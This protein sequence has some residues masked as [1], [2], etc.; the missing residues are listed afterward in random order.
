[1][2]KATIK[3]SSGAVITVEGTH[4]E[5]AR[6]I[7]NYEKTS[8]VGQ[9]KEAIARTKSIRNKEKKRA[10][11]GDLLIELRESGFFDK[12][13]TLA[14]MS[15]ALEEKGFLY[16][17]TSLSGVVLGLVKHRELR[18]KKLDGRWVYGK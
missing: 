10:G 18:R 9:A 3:S 15:D 17:T 5:V 6:I 2:A 16:P 1:M 8:I 12:P 7:S 4:E 14:E 11:A 13:K